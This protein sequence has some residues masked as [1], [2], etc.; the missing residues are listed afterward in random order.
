MDLRKA[1]RRTRQNRM[2]LKS[3]PQA[4]ASGAGT[5]KL[6][7]H[8]TL[9][10]SGYCGWGVQDGI[11]IPVWSHAEGLRQPWILP[12][13]YFYLIIHGQ[14]LN[15]ECLDIMAERAFISVPPSSS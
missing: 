11:G 14:T 7:Q 10:S 6:D 12:G 4:A 2:Q 3:G 9:E 15:D 8:Y 5:Q 13:R 1:V